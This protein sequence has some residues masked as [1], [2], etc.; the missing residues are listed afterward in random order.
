MANAKQIIE[1]AFENRTETGLADTP[2]LREAVDDTLARLNSGTLRVA[3]P[4]PQG[5]TV[6]EWAKKAVLLSFC[7]LYT[8]PSPRD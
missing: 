6:N 4:G 5:W 3:E 2:G 7:L 1:S 8:S